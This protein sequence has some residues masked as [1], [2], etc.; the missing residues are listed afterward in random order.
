MIQSISKRYERLLN[1][2]MPAEDR[3]FVKLSESYGKKCGEYTKYIIDACRPVDSKY[4]Q[5]LLEQGD[6]VENQLQKRI[7]DQYPGIEFRRQGSV[8]NNTHIKY[9]SDIDV[10]TIIDKFVTIQHPQVVTWP[11][12]G[13][14]EDDL[15]ALRKVCVNE[16][17]GAFPRA[18]VDDSGSTS[19]SVCGASLVCK[20]DIVPSNWFDTNEFAQSNQEHLR[21]IMVLNK[22]DMI[23]KKNYPFLFNSSLDK[24]DTSKF[25]LPRMLIRLLKTI[26]SDATDDGNKIDFSSYDI[27][28]IAY[29][30]PDSLYSLNPHTPLDVL[31]NFL[32]WSEYLIV[33]PSFRD[34]IG[35]IDGSRKIF[36]ESTKISEFRKLHLESVDLFTGAIKEHSCS[37]VSGSLTS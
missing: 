7:T 30:M 11:Y 26:R 31:R 9:Y 12:L 13:V 29:H 14:P 27:C 17:R 32:I 33:N 6:R 19:V 22:H 10:L 37:F 3:L 16:L 15:L 2:R 4:T 21:G 1:R 28:S 8:S 20:V 34:S 18:T 35:V 5:R 24:F 23:R 36:N 25:G